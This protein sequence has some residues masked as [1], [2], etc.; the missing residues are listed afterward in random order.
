MFSVL[1]RTQSELRRTSYLVAS[2]SR[3]CVEGT[4][5]FRERMCEKQ[6]LC[7]SVL[8]PTRMLQV[9]GSTLACGH[10]ARAVLNGKSEHCP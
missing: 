10:R 8:P 1:A 3:H 5:S 6:M 4:R 2:Q 9:D 7:S